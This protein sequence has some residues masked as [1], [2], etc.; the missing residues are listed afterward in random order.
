VPCLAIF[1]IFLFV[2]LFIYISN[3]DPPPFPV[4]PLQAPITSPLPFTSKKM[5]PHTPTHSCLTP[6][7]S[8][9]SGAS[10]LQKTKVVPIPLVPDKAICY[11]CTWSYDPCMYRLLVGGELWRVWLVDIVVLPMGLQSPPAPSVHPL[12]LPLGSLTSVQ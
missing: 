5:L 10:S 6:L 3:V 12:T 9:Y 11:I 7:A 4:S 1:S 2:I 8:P